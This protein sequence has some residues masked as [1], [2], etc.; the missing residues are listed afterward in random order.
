MSNTV[1][2][3]TWNWL[4]CSSPQAHWG[5]LSL[6]QFWNSTQRLQQTI[7][8]C[9]LSGYSWRV[10]SMTLDCDS[11]WS[12]FVKIPECVVATGCMPQPMWNWVFC[13]DGPHAGTTCT[14]REWQRTVFE[15]VNFYCG[16]NSWKRDLEALEGGEAI[17]WSM[18]VGGGA[19]VIWKGLTGQLRS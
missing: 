10:V 15:P 8:Y 19:G 3:Q 17:R 9:C 11:S 1:L 2:Y 7:K 18:G 13:R 16:D 4:W 6:F 14:S 5:Q 12:G